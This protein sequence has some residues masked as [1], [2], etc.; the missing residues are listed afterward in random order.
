MVNGAYHSNK[1]GNAVLGSYSSTT[2]TF[3]PL[4]NLDKYVGYSLAAKYVIPGVGTQM[5]GIYHYGKFTNDAGDAEAP[6]VTTLAVGVKHPIDQFAIGAQYAF[7]KFNNFTK[8][9]DTSLML[10]G[11]YNFSKRTKV[12]I[13]A[14]YAKDN[15]G[16]IATTGTGLPIDGGP[17]P[18]LTGFGSIETPF[19]SAA[20]ANI[21]ATT[22]VVAIGIRH[23]F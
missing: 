15:R 11:D 17:L 1:F 8:G 18:L 16:E 9:K 2:S 7:S 22:R 21:D 23:Q 14:G 4:A 5:S 12:Y 20:G 6:R 3:T 10:I 19:F 13:R